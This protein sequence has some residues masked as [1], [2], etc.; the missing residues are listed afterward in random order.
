[1]PNKF[2]FK[3]F[4]SYFTLGPLRAFD[5]LTCI[6]NMQEGERMYISGVPAMQEFDPWVRKIPWRRKWQPTPVFLPGK[7]HGQKSL[8]SYSPWVSKES[9]MTYMY[10]YIGLAKEF[11]WVFL[12]SCKQKTRTNF[13]LTQ[14]IYNINVS[15]VCLVIYVSICVTII[16]RLPRWR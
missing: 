6:V 11:I 8:A 16:M 4:R 1:M 13:W 10:K 3:R 12:V 14:Y 15:N 5:M 2:E 9:D 7:S